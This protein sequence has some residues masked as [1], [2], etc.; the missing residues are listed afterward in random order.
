MQI[1]AILIASLGFAGLMPGDAGFTGTSADLHAVANRKVHDVAKG[2]AERKAILDAVRAAN[3]DLNDQIPIV[4]IV[5]LL[6]SDGQEAFFRGQVRRKDNGGL[7]PRDIWGECEQ[8]P[9]DALLE[10]YLKKE[11]GRWRGVKANRCA[12]DFLLTTEEA[13]RLRSF[14]I[15]E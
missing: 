10:A 7:V 13:E 9:E 3:A 14:L 1:A 15:E 4:F 11:G 8:E 6:R 2:S 5:E 12:D